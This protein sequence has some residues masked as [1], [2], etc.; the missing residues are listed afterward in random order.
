MVIWSINLVGWDWTYACLL[1]DHS[2]FNREQRFI[3]AFPS[4]S[5]NWIN[6]VTDL[7]HNALAMSVSSYKIAS[8]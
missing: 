1:F 2:G 7:R 4:Y 5:F 3:T 6:D 8:S